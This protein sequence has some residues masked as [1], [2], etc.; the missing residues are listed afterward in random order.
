MNA[1][2]D[3]HSSI[4]S[5]VAARNDRASV[6]SRAAAALVL[7]AGL[8]T[9]APQARAQALA[10]VDVATPTVPSVSF[11][12]FSIATKAGFFKDEGL[13]FRLSTFDG[14]G[15]VMPLLL[16]GKVPIAF[17]NPSWLIFARQPGKEYAPV[18]FYYNYNRTNVWQIAVN[19]GSPIRTIA[20]LKGKLIGVPNPSGGMNDMTK[21]ML[22]GVGIPE[23]DIHYQTVGAGV[24]AWLALKS[25]KIDAL[26]HIKV[27]RA[28][29][30]TKGFEST[31]LDQPHRFT[32]IPSLG[33]IAREDT[34]EKQ[35]KLLIGV[36]RA[37]TKATLFCDSNPAACVKAFYQDYP[38]QAPKSAAEEKD[39]LAHDIHVL[40]ANLDGQLRLPGGD[41]SILGQYSERVWKTYID[42]LHESGEIKSR[43]VPLD[44]LYT[45][46]FLFAINDF[47]ALA[48]REK[49]K[50]WTN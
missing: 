45:D 28:R 3:R 39:Q 21:A 6:A 41:E 12:T 33:L 11:A 29:M 20:D 25:G 9:A 1:I 19:K 32:I 16:S 42:I 37:I 47:D 36:A 8:A 5:A 43:D 27:W 13:D 38:E 40:R 10:K 14:T 24:P 18:K 34:I 50:A 30:E 48:V 4:R 23:Q 7:V 2:D 46:K 44:S 22:K 31:V 26:L 35:P 15:V 17:S 49:A